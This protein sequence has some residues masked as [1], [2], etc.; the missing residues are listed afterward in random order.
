MNK[1]V[2]MIAYQFPPMGGAGVQRTS[3]FAKYLPL[4]GW[5]PTIYTI[6]SSKGLKDSSLM[7][8]IKDIKVIRSKSYNLME[9]R[10]PFNLIGKL[11]GKL[12]IPDAE[13][14]WYVK[15]R[16][17]ALKY[18]RENKPDVIYTTSYPYS[19]HLMGYYIK[20]AMPHIPWIVDFRDEWTNNPYILDKNYSKLRMKIEKN[21]ESNVVRH[22]DYFITNSLFMLEGFKKDYRLDHNA[23]VIPNG[24][25]KSDFE[26]LKDDR[27]VKDKL[28]ITYAGAMYGRRK[29]DT[30]LCALKKAIDSG[31]IDKNKIEVSFIGN[32]SPKNKDVVKKILGY[33]NVVSFLPYMEH[34]KSLQHLLNSDVLL[35]IVGAGKG[36]KN[37][38]TGKIFEYINTN[39]TILGLVPEDGAAAQVIRETN[40]GYFVDSTNI[41]KISECLVDIYAKWGSGKL[42]VDT[43]WDVVN[44]YDRVALTQQLSE[45]F[46]RSIER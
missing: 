39:R 9:W 15:N 44:Q 23:F 40:T 20:K 19:D 11:A 6:F 43:K 41:D 46:N 7:N 33:D 35:L 1:K 13:W 29:P 22:C 17:K 32:F 45:I 8:E 26:G 34:K 3:K 28:S 27:R 2:F 10:K 21:M 14:L 18:V 24:F 37:F 4:N 16:K 30:F 31:K 25:D 12:L 36:A 5:E 38:Y 42:K